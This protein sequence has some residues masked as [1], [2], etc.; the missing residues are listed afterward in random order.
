MFKGYCLWNAAKTSSYVWNCIKANGKLSP[1]PS[2]TPPPPKLPDS[3]PD[4]T[5]TKKEK[6]K[7]LYKC[8]YV[9]GTVLTRWDLT[10]PVCIVV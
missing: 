6:P 3:K 10:P 1:D 9:F 8:E 2:L 7:K 5:E 4:L